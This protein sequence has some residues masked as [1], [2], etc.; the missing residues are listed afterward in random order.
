MKNELER[1]RKA[2]RAFDLDTLGW[3]GQMSRHHTLKWLVCRQSCKKSRTSWVELPSNASFQCL[4]VAQQR[5]HIFEPWRITQKSS[6]LWNVLSISLFNLPFKHA[7]LMLDRDVFGHLYRIY[8]WCSEDQEERSHCHQRTSPKRD[9]LGHLHTVPYHITTE[10][11]I[12]FHNIM[13]Y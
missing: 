4:A 9:N 11:N 12:P 5:F 8:S 3:W 7:L 1:L 10:C 6:L 13:L 2:I